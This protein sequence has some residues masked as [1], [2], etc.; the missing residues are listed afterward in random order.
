MITVTEQFRR[1]VEGPRRARRSK[2]FE[3]RVVDVCLVVYRVADVHHR[4]RLVA[5]RYGDRL[6][7][8]GLLIGR[9]CASLVWRRA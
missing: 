3:L 1:T 6:I 2:L 9:W 4:P 8:Y 5:N 7:G